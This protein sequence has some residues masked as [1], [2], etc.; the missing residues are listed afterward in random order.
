MLFSQA[1]QSGIDLALNVGTSPTSPLRAFHKDLVEQVSIENFKTT[2]NY[3]INYGFSVGF[4]IDKINS[5]FFYGNRVSGAKTSVA[6]YSGYIRLTD[7]LKGHTLGVKYYLPIR[8]YSRG[9]MFAE[10]KGLVTFSGLNITSDSQISGTTQ[11]E[12]I[13]FKS[14]DFGLGGGF[15]YE[16]PLGFIVLKTYL[17]LD[18]Y[19]GGKIK[20]RENNPDGGYLLND[21]GEKVT[22]GWTGLT[23]GFGVT[24]P[25]GN[26]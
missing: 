14:T 2:D 1:Q 9:R 5:S 21:E 22:T 6:D 19:Y 12:S 16:Y 20:L 17:D 13:D 7:E 8:N 24:I 15:L 26:Q 18:I 4:T 3:Y 10:F 23:F 11:I 25:I